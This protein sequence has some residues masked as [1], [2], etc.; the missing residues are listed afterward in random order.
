MSSST[1][2]IPR[3]YHDWRAMGINRFS[4]LFTKEMER[5]FYMC[6]IAPSYCHNDRAPGDPV[7]GSGVWDHRQSKLYMAF[8]RVRV[9][10]HT[11]HGLAL[12]IKPRFTCGER[13]IW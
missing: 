13:K 7:I 9:R 1:R 3:I 4:F 8:G 6:D 12:I 11:I 10:S 2:F 5:N